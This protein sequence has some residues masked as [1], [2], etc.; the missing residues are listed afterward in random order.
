MGYPL[1]RVDIEGWSEDEPSVI[2]D[3]VASVNEDCTDR[4][5]TSYILIYHFCSP[6]WVCSSTAVPEP[7]PRKLHEMGGNSIALRAAMAVI[8][9]TISCTNPHK[10]GRE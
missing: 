1:H 4:F 3:F 2:M 5:I 6:P 9:A 10:M 8:C 7:Q